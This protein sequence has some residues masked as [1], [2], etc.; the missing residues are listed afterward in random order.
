MLYLFTAL[1]FILNIIEYFHTK[2]EI[3]YFLSFTQEKAI[4]IFTSVQQ[5]TTFQVFLS[6]KGK[7]TTTFIYK[8][9]AVKTKVRHYALE[10]S[11]VKIFQR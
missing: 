5:S 3:N 7:K 6:I 1:H 2:L 4:Q 8:N 10:C 11:E 9:S